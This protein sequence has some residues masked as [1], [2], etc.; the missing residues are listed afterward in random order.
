MFCIGG[1][2]YN[3]Y[4]MQQ[5]Y[6]NTVPFLGTVY[7]DASVISYLRQQMYANVNGLLIFQS[8]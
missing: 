6:V 3:Y 5:A 1:S 2:E 4:A 7:F 8:I